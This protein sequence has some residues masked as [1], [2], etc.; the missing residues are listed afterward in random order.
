[1]QFP[2]NCPETTFSVSGFEGLVI[3]QPFKEGHT[4]TGPEAHVLNQTMVENT[5]NNLRTSVEEAKEKGASLAD[6]QQLVDEYL[7][8]Y[9]FGARTGGGRIADPIK[10][11][12]ME[13]ARK[14]IRKA[15]IKQ[16]RRLKEITSE[17]INKRAQALL[18]HPDF[19]PR[20]MAQAK[21]TVA[22]REKD[23]NDVIASLGTP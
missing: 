8:K 9:E 18:D 19:G 2:A 21:K 12:A 17:E 10:A 15:F 1:M 16:G 22:D 5:R 11:Q 6:V 23:M 7:V 3:K 20:L 13:E 14:K 4:C